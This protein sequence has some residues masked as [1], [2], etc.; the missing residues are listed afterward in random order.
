MRA[1]DSGRRREG[2]RERE[3]GRER[4]RER[5][6]GRERPSAQ[7]LLEGWRGS[8]LVGQ[9]LQALVRQDPGAEGLLRWVAG[10]PLACLAP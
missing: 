2:E 9:A 6:R 3:C 5:E 8:E 10:G 7:P 4:E 1:G